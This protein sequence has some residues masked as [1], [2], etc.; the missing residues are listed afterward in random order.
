MTNTPENQVV[1]PS[2]PDY[3]DW[4]VQIKQR[5]ASVQMRI[6]LSANKELIF[7]YYDLG[8]KIAEREKNAAWGSAFIDQFSRD[9]K[10]DFPDISGFSAKNLRYCRAFY[11]FYSDAAIWQQAVAKLDEIDIWQTQYTY[12]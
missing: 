4:L 7:L 12:S 2:L 3:R 5:I 9:L 6:A 10:A 11:R 8:A 1:L